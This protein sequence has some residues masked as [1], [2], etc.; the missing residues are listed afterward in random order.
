M[1]KAAK[2]YEALDLLSDTPLMRLVR[3]EAIVSGS[4]RAM[5]ACYSTY[6]SHRMDPI[7]TAV[8]D[9][10]PRSPLQSPR[11]PRDIELSATNFSARLRADL[12]RAGLTSYKES[13]PSS[14]Q[15]SQRQRQE[16]AASERALR[17]AASDAESFGE[18]PGTKCLA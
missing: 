11:S 8:A 16:N 15:S 2:N 3:K 13:E 14:N 9:R 10:P 5:H 1:C 6:T 12:R 4:K 7:P 18:T 17:P